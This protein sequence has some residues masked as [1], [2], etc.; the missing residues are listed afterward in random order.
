MYKLLASKFVRHFLTSRQID[1]SIASSLR[2]SQLGTS[3]SKPYVTTEN[4]DAMLRDDFLSYDRGTVALMFMLQ[5]QSMGL[6]AET[7][8]N[9]PDLMYEADMY[10]QRALK[11]TGEEMRDV[12]F[13]DG[14]AYKVT[15][16]RKR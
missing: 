3:C 5:G 1:R 13:T 4:Y 12:G 6:N 16:I 9:F 11:A 2:S 15:L 14:N 7:N 8:P 10:G